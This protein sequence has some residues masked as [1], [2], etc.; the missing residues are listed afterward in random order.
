MT[1]INN[2]MIKNIV[3]ITVATSM[4]LF[5][6]ALATE[7]TFHIQAILV[8]EV[9]VD[10][11]ISAGTRYSGTSGYDE[12]LDPPKVPA[13]PFDFLA[14]FFDRPEWDSPYGDRY[15]GDFRE[16]TDFAMESE[17]W[18]FDIETDFSNAELLLAFNHWP[19]IDSSIALMLTDL[20][21]DIDYD[22]HEN[23]E[24]LFQSFSGNRQFLLRVGDNSAIESTQWSVIK[25]VF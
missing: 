24:V 3:L 22:L 8:S 16:V 5:S 4:A 23:P 15:S 11:P 20:D 6:T 1:H 13:Q 2:G 21:N 14:C 17:T 9:I 10:Q 7:Y 19:P 25:Q 18:R 12:G